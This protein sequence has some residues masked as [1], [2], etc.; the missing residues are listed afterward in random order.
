MMRAYLKR[1]AA[2]WNARVAAIADSPY[3]HLWQ[4]GVGVAVWTLCLLGL[5]LFDVGRAELRAETS[6]FFAQSAA[7]EGEL[8]ESCQPLV[9]GITLRGE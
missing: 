9:T 4:S 1:K 2:A 5:S 6:A 7:I 8:V 3:L